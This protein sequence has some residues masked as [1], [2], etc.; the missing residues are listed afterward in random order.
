MLDSRSP[1][2]RP[3]P[4]PFGEAAGHAGGSRGGGPAPRPRSP[5][6][7]PGSRRGWRRKEGLPPPRST[8]AGPP[9]SAPAADR[10]VHQEPRRPPG[11]P[12]GRARPSSGWLPRACHRVGPSSGTMTNGPR[13]TLR[14]AASARNEMSVVSFED[15]DVVR[16]A[17]R[18]E[19]FRDDEFNYQL[20]RA[21]GVADYGGST[22]GECLA[23]AAEITD[24]SPQQLGRGLRAPGPAGRGPG[25][26][27]SGGRPPGQR[28]G[29]L[30]AGVHLLPDG[31]VLRRRGEPAGPTRP[32]ERSRACFAVAAGLLDPPVELVDVPF[33]GGTLPGYL[34]R[35]R[36]RRSARAPSDP[37]RGGRIRLQRRG[38]LLPPGCARG[39]AGM[40]RLRL[41]RAGTARVHAP[42]P[43]A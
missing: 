7:R 11:W 25:P 31:R 12:G 1:P 4:G 27:L 34:V 18:V 22:V 35:P 39:R 21:L 43:D 17:I 28:P 14:P 41:R 38:A 3:R 15:S 20:I 26:G 5:W 10:L 2:A 23:V 9:S 8:R 37:G 29:P 40:E 42:Q 13:R 33:E 30:P 24:G 36:R 16:S 6:G 32:G 19:G